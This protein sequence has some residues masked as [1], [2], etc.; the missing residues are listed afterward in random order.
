MK[1]TTSVIE[2]MVLFETQ[3]NDAR[4]RKLDRYRDFNP[5]GRHGRYGRLQVKLS[6]NRIRGQITGDNKLHLTTFLK[7]SNV[8]SHTFYQEIAKS[9]RLIFCNILL[10]KKVAAG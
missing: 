7:E 2:L 10:K 9:A 3:V 6:C 5:Y 1:M 4:R 8:A